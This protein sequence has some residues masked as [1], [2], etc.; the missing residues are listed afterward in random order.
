M[1]AVNRMTYVERYALIACLVTF[2]SGCVAPLI[3]AG[4]AMGYSGYK[5]VQLAD[6]S[7]VGVRFG[8]SRDMSGTPLKAVNKDWR[9]AINA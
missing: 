9:M 4:A 7:E 6:G 5:M 2:L 8:Q 3:L 1:N